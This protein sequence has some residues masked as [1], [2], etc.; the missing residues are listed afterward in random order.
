MV[1][2]LDRGVGVLRAILSKGI[3]K[4][5]NLKM[6]KTEKTRIIFLKSKNGVT[7]YMSRNGVRS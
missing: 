6:G 4:G 2:M 3:T 7:H 5:I 1:G